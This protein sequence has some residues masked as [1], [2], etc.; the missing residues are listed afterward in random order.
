MGELLTLI[1]KHTSG[2]NTVTN[3]QENKMLKELYPII[4]KFIEDINDIVRKLE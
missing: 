3:Y 2:L 4:E 1:R